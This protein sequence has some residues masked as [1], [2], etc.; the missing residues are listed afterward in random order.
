MRVWVTGAFAFLV[1]APAAVFAQD[2]PTKDADLAIE[3]FNREFT[4]ADAKEDDQVLAVRKLGCVVHP[5]TMA[6]LN[7]L[8]SRGTACIRI[9]SAMGLVNFAGLADSAKGLIAAYS[10]PTNLAPAMRAVRIRILE[11]L[12][13]TKAEPAA[14]LVNAAILDKDVWIARAGIIA[15]SQI[16]H[17]ASI[18]ALL[19]RLKGLESKEG[20]RKIPDDNPG[21]PDPKKENSDFGSK[22]GKEVSNKYG[23]GAGSGAREGDRSER[24]ILRSVVD[25]ALQSITRQSF[26]S[27]EMWAKW[28]NGVRRDFQVPK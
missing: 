4:R 26:C 21:V 5:K 15:S 24:Q 23:E 28:W 18:D 7:G 19:C 17:R 6:V 14:G 11:T 1:A 3:D 13:A 10:N 25:E 2:D 22:S 12:G 9:S 16:R 8:L 27:F 20:E